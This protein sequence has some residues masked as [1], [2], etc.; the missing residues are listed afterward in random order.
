[1]EWASPAFRT[2]VGYR[3]AAT[4][5]IEIKLKDGVDP[6]Q[7][8]AGKV[9]A[10]RTGEFLPGATTFKGGVPALRL[11]NDGLRWRPAPVLRGLEALPV[12]F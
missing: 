3:L 5:R 2:K 10:Y 8:F 1:M 4:T 7:F 12:T 11:A 6:A 9:K